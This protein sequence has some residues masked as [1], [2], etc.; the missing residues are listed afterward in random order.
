MKIIKKMMNFFI[1]QKDKIINKKNN[2]KKKKI[3]LTWII[4]NKCYKI[5]KK[6]LKVWVNRIYFS[7]LL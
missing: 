2:M 6:T 4:S 3:T 1:I 5:Q 7:I